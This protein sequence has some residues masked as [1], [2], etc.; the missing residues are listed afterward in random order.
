MEIKKSGY[1][2]RNIQSE[3]QQTLNMKSH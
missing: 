2:T 1:W 3:P